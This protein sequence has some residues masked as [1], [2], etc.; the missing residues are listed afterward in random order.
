M[1]TGCEPERVGAER[2][3]DIGMDRSAI[4]ATIVCHPM[5]THVADDRRVDFLHFAL[6]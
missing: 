6:R 5:L 2:K 1:Q 3:F 4:E